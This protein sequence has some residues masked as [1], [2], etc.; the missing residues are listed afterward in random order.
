MVASGYGISVLP[1]GSLSGP[2][3]SEMVVSI[4]F[5]EPAPSRRV[6]LAW[7]RGF[8]P[9]K[10]IETIIAAVAAMKNPSYRVVRE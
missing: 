1:E 4:P 9:P 7:R 10:V 3:R 8:P 5:K 2:Y 6:A